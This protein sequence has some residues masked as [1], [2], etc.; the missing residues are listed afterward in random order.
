[1]KRILSIL[2]LLVSFCGL[3][4]TGPTTTFNGRVI[5]NFRPTTTTNNQFLT[6]NPTTGQVEFKTVLDGLSLGETSTTA[7]RGDRGKIAYDHSQTTGNPHNTQIGDISGL[8]SALNLKAPLAS[9]SLTGNPTAPTASPGTNSIQLATTAFVSNAVADIKIKEWSSG[10]Y[11]EGQFVTKIINNQQYLFRSTSNS[12]TTEPI[13]YGNREAWSPYYLGGSYI[14]AWSSSTTYSIGNIVE[15]VGFLYYCITSHTNSDPQTL[16][17]PNWFKIG[18]NFGSFT[19]GYKYP[20]GAVIIGAGN[21]TY[22]SNFD[23]NDRAINYGVVSK[24]DVIYGDSFTVYAW[25]DSLTYGSG[26][27]GLGNYPSSLFG[28]TGINIVN[29]GVPGETST[30]IRTRF[31]AADPDIYKYPVIFWVGRNNYGDPTTVLAD[32]AAMIAKLP[33]NNYLVIGIIKAHGEGC[34]PV[35]NLN[36]SLRSAYPGRFVELQDYLV[37]SYDPGLTQDVSDHA[38]GILPWSVLSDWLHLNNKGYN[39]VAKRIA[40][41]INYL[42]GNSTGIYTNIESG[43]I[44]ITDKNTSRLPIEGLELAYIDANDTG[45]ISAINGKD[46][47]NRSLSIQGNSGATLKVLENGGNLF[48]G[49]IGTQTTEIIQ[50][51]GRDIF[52]GKLL[53]LGGISQGFIPYGLSNGNY[54]ASNI[55]Y[56]GTQ[57]GIGTSGDF[58]SGYLTQINNSTA[59]GVK[60]SARA[61]FAT[62]SP[63]LFLTQIRDTDLE[64]DW[65]ISNRKIWIG[66]GSDDGTNSKLQ[67]TGN[68]SASGVVKMASPSVGADGANKSYVDAA[69]ALKFNNPTGTASDLIR[70]DG[71]IANAFN[72]ITQTSVGTITPTNS[73][74]VNGNNINLSFSKTQGQINALTSYASKTAGYTITLLDYFVELTS[75][76]STFTLP[77][78]VGNSGKQYVVKNSGSGVLTVSTTSS[79]TIDGSASLVLFNTNSTALLI[80][81]GANWKVS[82][83]YNTSSALNTS[84]TATQTAATLNAAYPN[85][86]SPFVVYAPNVGTGMVFIK[87]TSGGQ[88][89]QY[90]GSLLNP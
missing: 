69:D 36:N 46:N 31:E 32:L 49:D 75:S 79:Q 82:D 3:S 11:S 87:T 77:T 7:Y 67:V 30:Q 29:K 56:N 88:W 47:S 21:V 17:P 5:F 44:Q 62:I 73:P 1:M 43:F 24:W 8:Q 78:A 89:M 86:V 55:Y 13:L 58:E 61:Y 34:C 71:S 52:T 35:E 6:I 50:R 14:G 37:E 33:H 2:V 28:I 57:L 83:S 25:G 51:I 40:E 20:N 4:Q 48:T 26:S 84:L 54:G 60:G 45:Y 59:I 64:Y 41:K 15:R 90:S 22:L 16:T 63:T 68:I 74:I 10:T 12:N 23:N 70:G 81:D 9:P 66:S 80:S 42:K 19:V 85:A 39:L 38:S 18:Q 53:R 27:T 65:W 72:L 76:T